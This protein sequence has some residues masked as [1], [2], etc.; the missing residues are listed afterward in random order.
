MLA[1][2]LARVALVGV[3]PGWCFWTRRETSSQLRNPR[4]RAASTARAM[5]PARTE[6]SRSIGRSRAIS[7]LP[8]EDA[9]AGRASGEGTGPRT[10]IAYCSRL[11]PARTRSTRLRRERRRR[12]QLWMGF[13]KSHCR[14]HRSGGSNRKHGL[15]RR[16][17]RRSL[18]IYKC[19]TSGHARFLERDLDSSHRQS[20]H[21][22]RGCNRHSARK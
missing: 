17:V 15:H 22:C 19:D 12:G 10:R 5:V 9:H 1:P 11:E 8:S 2:A 18:E 7:S 21:A 16:G 13:R 6:F 4:P 20:G 3:V 14:G